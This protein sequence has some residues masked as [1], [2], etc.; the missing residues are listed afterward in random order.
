MR[1]IMAN[2]NKDFGKTRY[3]H[4]VNVKLTNEDMGRMDEVKQKY[5][6]GDISWSMLVRLL[7]RKGLDWYAQEKKI[8]GSKGI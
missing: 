3:P 8:N 6:N 4:Q 7:V 2:T 5:L 1:Y